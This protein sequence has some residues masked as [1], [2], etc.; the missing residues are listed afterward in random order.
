VY[1]N[2]LSPTNQSMQFSATELG[3]A[4]GLYMINATNEAGN[5]T[6]KLMVGK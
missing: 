1:S 5:H 2:I 4:N 6:Q 3:L